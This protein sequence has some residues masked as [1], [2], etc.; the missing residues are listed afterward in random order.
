MSFK[1]VVFFAVYFAALTVSPQLITIV[2]FVLCVYACYGNEQAIKALS[3]GAITKYLNPALYSF[4]AET[5]LLAWLLFF[6]GVIRLSLFTIG[7]FKKTI[8]LHLFCII[9]LLASLIASK[10]PDVSSTKIIMFDLGAMA[11]IQGF[12]SMTTEQAMRIK[13]WL[14]SLILTIVL[15]SLPTFAFPNIAYNRNGAGFQGI[16][17]H[18]QSFGPLLAP[19]ASWYLV[20][21]IFHK[22]DKFI[23]PFIYSILLVA[24]MV[25]S[26]AR[27]SLASVFLTLSAVFVLILFRSKYFQNTTVKKSIVSGFASILIFTV[28]VTSSE[29]IQDKLQ[30]FIFKRQSSNMEEALSSRSHGIA[31]QWDYFIESP[32]V[33]N[34]FGV[35]SW[36]TFPKGITYYMGIPISAPVE[37]GFLPTCILEEVGLLGTVFFLF[38]VFYLLKLV[39]RSSSLQVTALFFACLFVNVGEMVFFSLGGIGLFYWLLMGLSFSGFGKK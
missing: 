37:K 33:G 39:L 27:T 16:L 1:L 38:L 34:G 23:F 7:N 28:A 26:Q 5:G 12:Y 8:P 36:G 11:V 30:N 31:S 22:K 14:F 32:L 21:L 9:A 35:Y 18:P 24:L 10:N 2:F 25:A 6:I 29:L 17:N 19:M 15:L 4:S 13:V 20:G 3:L